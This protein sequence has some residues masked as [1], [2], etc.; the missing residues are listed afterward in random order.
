MQR[1]GVDRHELRRL[2]G[3]VKQ[4][5]ICSPEY[6]EKHRQL[7]VERGGIAPKERPKK[8]RKIVLSEAGRTVHRRTLE[9]LAERPRTPAQMAAS[10]ANGIKRGEQLRK[11]RQPCAN[12][13]TEVPFR[14]SKAAAKTCSAQCLT[15]LKSRNMSAAR[16]SGRL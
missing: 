15:E 16:R 11:P 4:A 8:G 9:A 1:H 5:S 12:C 2:A 7:L 10:K 6:S 3:L 14:P 13:G